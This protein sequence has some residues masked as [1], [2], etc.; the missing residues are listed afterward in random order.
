VAELEKKRIEGRR[1]YMDILEATEE[2][3]NR[4]RVRKQEKKLKVQH[5]V[6]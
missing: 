1:I 4:N 2:K 3:K 6:V 5:C